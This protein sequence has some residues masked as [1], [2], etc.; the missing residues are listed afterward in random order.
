MENAVGA[1]V[2]VA[3]LDPNLGP[4]RGELTSADSV[5]VLIPSLTG[6]STGGSPITSYYIEFDDQTNGVD[7]YELQG[8]TTQTLSLSYLKTG[9]VTNKNYQFRYKARNIFGW[10][11]WSPVGIIRTITVPSKPAVPTTTLQADNVLIEWVQPSLGG[12]DVLVEYEIKIRGKDNQLYSELTYCNGQDALVK[13]NAECLIPMSVFWTSPF[14]LLQDD[15]IQLKVAT[16]NQLGWGEFSD[17]NTIGLTVQTKPRTPTIAVVRNEQLCTTTAISVQMPEFTL[18]ESGS[19]DITSYN[20]EWNTGAGTVFY[21]LI[22]ETADNLDRVYTKSALTSGALYSFRY[23]I[24]NIYGFSD[25]S[26]VADIFCAKVPA[27]VATPTLSYVGKNVQID[28]N[29]PD[30]NFNSILGYKIEI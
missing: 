18:S 3:P 17:Q 11:N 2:R 20:L 19:S 13:Q 6:A 16:K 7:W 27:Q 4:Y 23:R 26:P 24:K 30:S 8:F 21:E 9:L 12:N 14:N 10:S 22:G 28:W 29:A 25:Y 1:D 5:Q 15:L